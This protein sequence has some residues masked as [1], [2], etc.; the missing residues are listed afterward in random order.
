MKHVVLKFWYILAFLCY[1]PVMSFAQAI[2]V[3]GVV[4]DESGETLIGVSVQVK[5]TGTGTITDLDGQFVLSSVSP[6]AVLVFSYVGYKTLEL[7]PKA[8]MQVTMTSDTQSLDEVVVVAYGV[9]KKVTVTGA[10]SNVNSKELLKSPSASLGNALAGKLPGVQSVQ[11]SG[12]PG[13]DDP[14]I[15]VRGVGSLNSAEPLVLVD[16]VERPFSQLD[17]NEVQDISILKDASATAVY[18]VRGA[19][20][21]ILVTTKRGEEGKASISVS[22]SAG[23]QQITQFLD[24]TNS[25]TYAAAYNNAQLGD[26]ISPDAVRYSQTAIQHFKDRDMLKVYP[27]TNWLDYIMKNSAWQTQYN[28]SISGGSKKAKY[29]IS[30]GA[31]DQDGLFKTFNADPE[32]NFKYK[33]YNYRANLDLELSKYSSLAINIGGRLENRN[34]IG[35]GESDLFRYLHSNGW[36]WY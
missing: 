24:M 3:K 13:G 16:G 23:L 21:V 28:V 5:G 34:T 9:Q 27:D 2:N 19:N 30:I 25:Y 17:P 4:E 36:I 33:R 12:I 14:V 35:D 15:R 10:V 22:A 32:E 7:K 31:F 29:F 1:I 11:Y 18:G 6:D 20:G 26:G 8:N